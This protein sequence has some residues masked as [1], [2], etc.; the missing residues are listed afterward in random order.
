MK[1]VQINEEWRE[2]QIDAEK[3]AEWVISDER[4]IER[5]ARSGHYTLSPVTLFVT[6]QLGR[7]QI[8]RYHH[9]TNAFEVGG[10]LYQAPDWVR[11]F[12]SALSW[13]AGGED[14]PVSVD[15]ILEALA[16]ALWLE[17]IKTSV[18]QHQRS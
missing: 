11:N 10:V 18:R 14:K 3:F 5:H 8:A 2:V 7:R 17:V 16:D 12:E 9:D 1:A 13:R 4:G 15:Q 6:T